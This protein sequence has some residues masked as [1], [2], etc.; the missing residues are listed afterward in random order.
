MSALTFDVEQFKFVTSA[1]RDR[2]ITKEEREGGASREETGLRDEARTS[3]EWQGER[4]GGLTVAQ[5]AS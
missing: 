4:E 3:V 1:P 5:L 2:Q